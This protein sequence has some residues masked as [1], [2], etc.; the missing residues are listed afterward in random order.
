M[1]ALKAQG[2]FRKTDIN[3]IYDTNSLFINN[4]L[5]YHYNKTH[6]TNSANTDAITL[7]MDCYSNPKNKTFRYR[8]SK[9]YW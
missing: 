9:S 1:P 3:H 8:D 7:E 5:R 4:S 6:N 2:M